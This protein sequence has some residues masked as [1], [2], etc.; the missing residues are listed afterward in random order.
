MCEDSPG[1]YLRIIAGLIPREFLLEVT[2]EGKTN[3]VINAQPQLTEK[4]WRLQH[5]LEIPAVEV[6]Q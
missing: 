2:Q 4:A 6:D 3:W 5:N 1:E